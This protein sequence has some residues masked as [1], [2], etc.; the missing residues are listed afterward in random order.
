MTMTL[1]KRVYL[2]IG[3]VAILALAFS[4][5]TLTSRI[6]SAGG[7]DST[8]AAVQSCDQEDDGA[9]VGESADAADIDDV[10]EE[11]GPQDEAGADGADVAASCSDEDGADDDASEAEE[12]P[13][14]D[15]IE[16]QCGP[17]DAQD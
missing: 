8:A 6:T 11:C 10:E 7:S 5:V 3:L 9:E 15:N 1:S 4:A 17:Q 14:T 13:D 16:E 12:G 2:A